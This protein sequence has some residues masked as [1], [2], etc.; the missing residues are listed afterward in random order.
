MISMIRTRVM[1][2]IETWNMKVTAP[3]R[4]GKMQLVMFEV[5]AGW[6][7]QGIAMREPAE[8][9]EFKGHYIFAGV[10][11]LKE[12]KLYTPHGN[13]VIYE[14]DRVFMVAEFRVL[15]AVSAYLSGISG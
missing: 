15:K 5:P 11:S 13:D 3:I 9:K 14:G 2:D 1:T 10:F 4:E 7:E 12:E 6:P 8:Q